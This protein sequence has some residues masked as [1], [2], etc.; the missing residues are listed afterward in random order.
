MGL[1]TRATA[2]GEPDEALPFLTVE[3]ARE[4]RRLAAATL[5]RAGREVV[6]H[7]DHLQGS[8]G[9]QYGLWN[10]AAACQAAGPRR[11]WRAVVEAHVAALLDAPPDPAAL[12]LDELLGGVVA[13]VQGTDALPDGARAWLGYATP[14]AEGLLEVLAYDSP[15]TVTLLSDEVVA[16][17]GQGVLRA[18]G[19]ANLLREP[20]GDVEHLDVPG[21][22]V[23]DLVEGESVHTASQVLVLPDVLRHL[24]GER[25]Y[26]DGVLVGMPDRHHLLVHAA[27]GPDVLPAL[28]AMA[29]LVAQ[30]YATGVGGVSPSVY[31]WRDGELTCLSVLGSDGH[32]R[33]E[34]REEFADVLN[35]LAGG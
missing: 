34:V 22:A 29:P 2:G 10:V 18:A 13:R 6:I 21:G 9:Q 3:E 25:A 26:P 5:A 28:Q 16:R 23:V 4:V 27:D 31:W 35:R 15:S 19:L 33:V 8:D 12:S 11:R 32:L 30:Q 1:F 24:H 14:L 20:L 17:H 7:D